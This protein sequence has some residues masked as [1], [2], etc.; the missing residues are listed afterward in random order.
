DRLQHA[1][2][3]R[4]RRLETHVAT[5]PVRFEL[6]A[7]RPG[8]VAVHRCGDEPVRHDVVDVD[9][10]AQGVRERRLDETL[11]R[12]TGDERPAVEAAQPRPPS[13]VLVEGGD[14]RPQ[15]LGVDV[16]RPATIGADLHRY[17]LAGGGGERE[18]ERRREGALSGWPAGMRSLPRGLRLRPYGPAG[19][20][21]VKVRP[22]FCTSRVAGA[23]P[24]C[25]CDV[26]PLAPTSHQ[27]SPGPTTSRRRR[28]GTATPRAYRRG[29]SLP[30]RRARRG[31]PAWPATAGRPTN[32]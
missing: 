6:E 19:Q 18:Q 9:A 5:R 16:E 17:R 1:V 7:G 30:R 15:R 31:G 2:G 12:V 3:G 20:L 10:E 32:R 22:G 21:R 27:H 28:G 14:G 13:P 24:E 23:D 25:W 29:R 26:G 8:D 4:E 11:P